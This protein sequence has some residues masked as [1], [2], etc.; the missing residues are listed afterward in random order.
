MYR[1]LRMS[2]EVRERRRQARHPEY[3]KPEFLA[4]AP[5]QCWS[6]DINKLR[7]PNRGEW[8]S[9]LVMLDVFSR[10][11]VVGLWCGE[12]MQRSQRNSSRKRLQYS[13]LLRAL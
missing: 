3:V 7:G 11:V 5:N 8:Y 12:P 9:L 6:W 4:T 10:M 13:A 1:L 2:D